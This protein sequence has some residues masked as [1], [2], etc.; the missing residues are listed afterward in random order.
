ML[1]KQIAR[2]A[3]VSTNRLLVPRIPAALVAS[4]LTQFKPLLV[5]KR[6][7]AIDSGAEKVGLKQPSWTTSILL[8]LAVVGSYF[9]YQA[10]AKQTPVEVKSKKLDYQAVYNRIAAILEDNDY[11]DGSYGPV[12]VRLAWHA[13]GTFDKSSQTGGSNGATMRYGPEAS[14]GANA[15]LD[16]A[17]KLLEPI[18]KEFPEL[19]YADLW[20]LAGV[21]AIQEMGGPV[22]PWR[23]GRTD[24][25]SEA[26][27]PP[28]GRL[29]DAAKD[30]NHVRAVFSRMGFTDQEIVALVGAHALGRCHTD[31]SGFD[32]PWTFSPT[33]FTN[34]YFKRL[35]G[36]KWVE[37]KWKG[38]KQYVDKATG[39]LMMLPADLALIKDKS[40]KQYVDLYAKDEEKFF[41]DFSSAFAKLLELGIAYKEDAEVYKFKTT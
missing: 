2:T 39:N 23:A 21:V 5:N 14:D 1:S 38:P 4:N 13:S 3:A 10:Y 29:P 41:A 6:P 34:D 22:V 40:F 15:G 35:V 27:C 37:K 33:T 18:K 25:V 28:Q 9:A 16:V 24:A 36:E 31:R 30:Q 12:L 32:G 7:F 20:T 19:S 17:R 8:S 26:A 11:D